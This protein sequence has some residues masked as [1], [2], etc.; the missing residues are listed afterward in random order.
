MAVKRFFRRHITHL[1]DIQLKIVSNEAGAVQVILPKP[2]LNTTFLLTPKITEVSIPVYGIRVN[3]IGIDNRGIQ[4]ISTVEVAV[5]VIVAERLRAYGDVIPLMPVIDSANAFVVQSY[6]TDTDERRSH[7]VIIATEDSTDINITFKTAL[8]GN[9]TLNNIVYEDGDI[10]NITLNQLQT[11]YAYL[12]VNDLSGSLI[13][14]NRP[15]AVFSGADC[16]T[17]PKDVGPCNI[18]MSQMTPVSQ[19]GYKYIVPPIYPERCHVRVFAFHDATSISVN[20]NFDFDSNVT[21]NQGEFWETT[22]YDYQA[23]PLVISSDTTIN[24]VLY[25][26]SINSLNG[27]NSRPFMLVVPDIHQYSTMTTTF[28]VVLYG[29]LAALTNKHPFENYAAIV[30]LDIS[31]NQLQY[32][33]IAPEIIKSYSVLNKYTVVIITLKNVTTHTI[34]TVNTSTPILMAVF[35]YGVAWRESYGFVAGFKSINAGNTNM[36]SLFKYTNRNLISC[37]NAFTETYP[38][39]ST[40][41]TKTSNSLNRVLPIK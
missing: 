41:L 38:I 21:L 19:W 39:S 26:A 6:E 29:D 32:N 27:H 31:F 30:L 34:S 24:V 35:V 20:A 23:Q 5:Y 13:E 37:L 16:V 11:F 14:S 15:I 10:I 33:G 9:V 1:H 18:I 17:I 2:R 40:S 3:D 36:T 7:F 8:P 22:L 28:P 12:S 25:G 4:I